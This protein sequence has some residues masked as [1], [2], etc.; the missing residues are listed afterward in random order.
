MLLSAVLSCA[1]LVMS[2]LSIQPLDWTA[3]LQQ[4]ALEI[5]LIGHARHD[6]IIANKRHSCRQHH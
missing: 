2:D 4:Q 3:Q 6:K 1:P 5:L